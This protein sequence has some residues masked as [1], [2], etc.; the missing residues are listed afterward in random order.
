MPNLFLSITISKES[1]DK[2]ERAIERLEKEV[3]ELG[4]N[5]TSHSGTSKTN[6]EI[7]KQRLTFLKSPR[8]WYHMTPI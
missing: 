3:K 8:Q 4:N 7:Q 5:L 6:F 1:I 2:Y